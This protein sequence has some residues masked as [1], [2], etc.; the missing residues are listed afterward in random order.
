MAAE[1][2]TQA[3]SEI[4][5]NVDFTHASAS[6][7]Q[8]YGA[9][10]LRPRINASAFL[11]LAAATIISASATAHAA[12]GNLAASQAAIVHNRRRLVTAQIASALHG[13]VRSLPYEGVQH[14]YSHPSEALLK[15]IFNNDAAGVSSLLSDLL[16]DRIIGADL[17][18]L[19]GRLP[20]ETV[21]LAETDWRHRVLARSLVSSETS[22]REAAIEAIENW[23]D[24]FGI[25]LLSSHHD[26]RPWLEKYAKQVVEDNATASEVA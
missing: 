10:A 22:I 20:L 6:V 9:L 24:E 14:G 5:N 25:G 11:A 1:S 2:Q 16:F 4:A 12:P 21:N 23:R 15:E 26:P 3:V 8:P 13:I 18:R 19:V 17:L 7:T